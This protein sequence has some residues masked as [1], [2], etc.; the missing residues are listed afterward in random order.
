[1][2]F[3]FGVL[4]LTKKLH[5]DLYLGHVQCSWNKI[6]FFPLHLPSPFS[7]DSLF[8]CFL[9]PSSLNSAWRFFLPAVDPDSQK[10]KKKKKKFLLPSL[11]FPEPQLT[12][13]LSLF[14]PSL[15]LPCLFPSKKK[16]INAKTFTIFFVCFFLFSFS[17]P[18][19]LKTGSGLIYF[20]LW[21]L[22]QHTSIF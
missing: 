11:L 10:K 22:I 20:C 21:F 17:F 12:F 16:N 18:F 6:T 19:L 13:P 8:F 1:M 14:F 9:F 7:Q 4:T 5:F 3:L 2:I 15:H